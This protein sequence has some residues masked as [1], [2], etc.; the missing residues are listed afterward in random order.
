MSAIRFTLCAILAAAGAVGLAGAGQAQLAPGRSGHS[1]AYYV[2]QEEAM[3]EVGL[4]GRCYAE[5][6]RNQALA[7]IATR[8]SSREEAETYRNLFR[9]DN[10][11]CLPNGMSLQ[12]PLAYV[13]GAIAEGLVKAGTGVPASHLLPAPA[14]AEV[15]NL[16][17]VARCHV[18]GHRSAIRP[19][20]DT[21]PGSREE[22]QAVAAQM[23]G[24][25]ACTPAG[26]KLQFDST[27]IRYRLAEALLRLAPA[28][29]A[30]SG[31]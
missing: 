25:E 17:D 15:R 5:R 21:K 20:L 3:R 31:Q 29:T 22:Y 16:S 11:I 27:V 23:D 26:V 6:Q 2:G 13:R 12:A 14:V 7:L 24:L 4:F 8:P 28:G 9:R 10:Q 18:A 30:A 1:S 19:L